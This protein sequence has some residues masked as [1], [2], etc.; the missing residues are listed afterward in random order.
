MMKEIAD[1]KNIANRFIVIDDDNVHNFISKIAISKYNKVAD[2]HLHTDAESA[3][4]SLKI[5][6]TDIQDQVK[7]I[8]LLDINMP[9][10]NGWEFLDEFSYFGE[11][12]LKQFIIY[13]C[14]SSIDQTDMERAE[15]HVFVSGFLSKPLSLD[16]L[17]TTLDNVGLYSLSCA[18]GNSI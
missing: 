12:V 16:K 6:I 8:I 10:M 13:M 3:L 9:G 18:K 1:L 11:G 14:S 17:K 5:M 4:D 2:V 7:T 15:N